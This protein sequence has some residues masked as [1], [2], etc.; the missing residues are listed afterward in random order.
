MNGPGTGDHETDRYRNGTIGETLVKVGAAKG[1]G[2]RRFT[3][4]CR[5]ASRLSRLRFWLSP[6]RRIPAQNDNNLSHLKRANLLARASPAA[7]ASRVALAP[8][9]TG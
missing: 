5:A 7:K 4:R 1:Y 6:D 2:P 9:L 3:E 8:G